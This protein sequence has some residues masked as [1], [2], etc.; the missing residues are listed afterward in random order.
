[1]GSLIKGDK[2]MLKIGDRVKLIKGNPFGKIGKIILITQMTRPTN[3]SD[4]FDLSKVPLENFFTAK[5][6]DG[7]EFFGWEED[8]EKLE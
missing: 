1:M 6:D 4:G 5:A 7:T 2:E 3:V 8:F